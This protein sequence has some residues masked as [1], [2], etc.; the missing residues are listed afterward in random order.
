MAGEEAVRPPNPRDSYAFGFSA[1]RFEP[2][3]ESLLFSGTFSTSTDLVSGWQ[4][5]Y[6]KFAHRIQKAVGAAV[7][8]GSLVP[9][10]GPSWQQHAHRKLTVQE[11]NT[12]NSDSGRVHLV[13]RRGRW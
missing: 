1:A 6:R 7:A 2:L 3:D 12:E 4:R 10:D 11:E 5:R 13:C 8:C 9:P